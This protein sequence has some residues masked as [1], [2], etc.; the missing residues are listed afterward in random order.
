MQRS[1]HGM[2]G[3]RPLAIANCEVAKLGWCFVGGCSLLATLN[4]ELDAAVI[5]HRRVTAS[6]DSLQKLNVPLLGHLTLWINPSIQRWLA[7]FNK[8]LPKPAK[9]I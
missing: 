6:A 9:T 5:Y 1:P 8:T 2:I 3:P 7:L 4:T